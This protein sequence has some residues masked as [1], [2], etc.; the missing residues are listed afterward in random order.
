M[1]LGLK[2][3]CL[4]S[5]LAELEGTMAVEDSDSK[6]VEFSALIILYTRHA[7]LRAPSTFDP[8]QSDKRG[9]GSLWVPTC[10]GLWEEVSDVCCGHT[11]VC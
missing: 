2:G 6:G 9:T 1:D 5:S 11:H 7:G 8:N 3:S 4:A 10:L